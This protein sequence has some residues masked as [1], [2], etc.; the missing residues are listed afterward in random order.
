MVFLRVARYYFPETYGYGFSFSILIAIAVWAGLFRIARYCFNRQDWSFIIL[1]P[2]LWFFPHIHLSM[3]H[4]QFTIVMLPFVLYFYVSK[5][6]SPAL[7]L[8][9][10][11]LALSSLIKHTYLLLAIALISLITIDEIGKLKRIPQVAAIYLA[12][13]GIFWLIAAQDMANI[14]AYISNGLEIIRGFSA[15]MGSPGHLDEVL[16]Y[17]FTTG[18]FAFLVGVIEWKN[19]RWWGSLPILGL[20]GI[21]FIT[22]KGAFTRH[23]AHALQAMYNVTPVMLIFMALLWPS[24]KQ[25][26]WHLGKKIKLPLPMFFGFN[27]ILMIML[28]SILLQHYQNYGYG[29]YIFNVANYAVKR[30][31]QVGRT[32]TGNGNFLAVAEQGKAAIRAAN[33]LPPVSGT[34]DLYPNETATLFSYDLEYQPRPTF[35][36]FSAYTSKLARLNAEHLTSSEA[37]ENLLFDLRA[38]DNRMAS[39]EDGLSWPEI[40]T[41]Y[42]I[43][44]VE[45]RYLL[46]KKNAQPRP[47]ELKPIQNTVNVALNEWFDVSELQ[48]P[49][50]CKLDIHPNLIGKLT[51]AI[52]RLPPINIEIETADGLITGYR[53]IGDVMSEGFLLS[54]V[55]S[56]RWDFIDFAASDWQ[57]RLA[58]KQVTRFRI[59]AEGFNAQRYPEEY[60]VSFSQLEF[61]RQSFAGVTGWQEWNNQIIPIPIE[62]YLQRVDI[63]DQ[64][65]VGWLAHPPMK[66]KI[67]LKGTEQSFSANFGILN[68]A[69]ENAL[70]DNVGDGVE[71]KIIAV[72][73]DGQETLLFSRDLQPKDNPQDRGIQQVKIDLGQINPT[74]LILET[75]SGKDTLYDWSYWSEL[76]LE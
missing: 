53:T 25:T 28:S 46:L 65:E 37:A 9:I 42:D 74:Q 38:I 75:S 2:I 57:K 61:S 5:R 20:L 22:F 4:F 73:S 7:V 60:Q 36:S 12:F 14:P 45:N 32:L 51:T 11:N 54:P 76:K 67:E 10:I 1:M 56:T 70:R 52:L 21:F 19:R 23:D 64:D 16:L 26:S 13:L 41:R 15:S 8:T 30:I 71:F 44:N 27:A 43:A 3:D 49:L 50:W 66:T 55:L 63:D 17:V 47:Y 33:I 69:V 68:N 24:I 58:A 39:F 62:G 40:L 48:N 31:P 35:Q 6:M 29:F 18:L 59:V 34:V 72:E